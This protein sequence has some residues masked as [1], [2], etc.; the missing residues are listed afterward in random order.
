[1]ETVSGWQTR[2]DDPAG[3][4]A[5]AA[6]LQERVIDLFLE[7]LRRVHAQTG[8]HRLCLAGSL[9]YH[10]SVI[11]A[12]RLQGPFRDVFAPI[13]PGNAGLAVGASLQNSAGMPQSVSPFLG[14]SYPPDVIKE[15]LDNC[16]LS[17]SWEP[18]GAI[19]DRVVH[20]LQRG[21]LIGWFDGPMEW[22]PRALGG[23]SILANPF[24][25]FVLENLNRFLKRRE[26]WRG[27]ALSGLHGTIRDHFSGPSSSHFMECDYQPRDQERFRH[28][29]P[30][31]GAALRVQTVGDHAPERFAKLLEAFGS[32]SGLPVLVNTSFNGFHEPIVCS[33]RDAVRVFFG[34]GLDLLVLGQF[35]VSK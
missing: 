21:G 26:S 11:T 28:V 17:Y 3:R 18:E 4:A 16:K 33:P 13:D 23:R 35:V 34:S 31:P 27:Y 12:A 10:S 30:L 24:S 9:F 8:G 25:P 6:G 29:L 14:P 20:S 22:G 15:T 19:V 1:M 2:D 7:F 5:L 32:A